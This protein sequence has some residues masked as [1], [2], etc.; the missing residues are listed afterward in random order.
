MVDTGLTGEIMSY[1]VLGLPIIPLF[2]LFICWL[3]QINGVVKSLRFHL[4]VIFTLIILCLVLIP[5]TVV[6]SIYIHYSS[7][8][9]FQ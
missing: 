2:F 4:F 8:E 1:I 3:V 5:S 9:T 6:S 7:I